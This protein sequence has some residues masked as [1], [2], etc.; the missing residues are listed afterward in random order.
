MPGVDVDAVGTTWRRRKSGPSVYVQLTKR[1]ADDAQ[2]G[3]F[4]WLSHDNQH[5]GSS[6]IASLHSQ[7]AARSAKNIG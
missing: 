6:T 2:S 4:S 5:D 7:L 3:I 1:R